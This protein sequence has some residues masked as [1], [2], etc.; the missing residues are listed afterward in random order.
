MARR[1]WKL[2]DLEATGKPRGD[3]VLPTPSLQEL[4][5]VDKAELQR[6]FPILKTKSRELRNIVSYARKQ[7]NVSHPV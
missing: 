5:G 7:M 3:A 2:S 6:L 4:S 1:C